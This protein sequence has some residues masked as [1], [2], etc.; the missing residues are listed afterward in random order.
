MLKGRD[1]EALH[2]LAAL[3]DLP[4]DDEKVQSEFQAVKDVAFEMAKG[5]F[6]ECAKTNR[7]RNLHRTILG[8]VNQMFQQIS[9]INIIS[10]YS[11]V[12]DNCLRLQLMISNTKSLL[13]YHYFRN[14][15]RSLF[16]PKPAT[17]GVQRY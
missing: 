9:G 15:D 5:G 8:Y 1:D 3:A 16:L 11:F 12:F 14:K 17:C 6:K 4:E 7:N 2:V 10:A 13:C